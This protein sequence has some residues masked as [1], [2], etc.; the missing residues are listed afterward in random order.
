MISLIGINGYMGA[1]KDTVGRIIQ[2]LVARSNVKDPKTL[3]AYDKQ[4]ISDNTDYTYTSGWEIRKFA[5][6]LKEI[7]SILTG[8]PIEKFEDPEFKKK[9]F[10]QLVEEGYLSQEVL[11]LLKNA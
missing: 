7:A 3:L 4:G 2:F 8:I 1:G 9:T 6:K 5:G 10:K 11:E